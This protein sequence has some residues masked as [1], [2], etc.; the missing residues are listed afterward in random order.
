[1]ASAIDTVPCQLGIG[2][3]TLV[4]WPA[5]SCESAQRASQLIVLSMVVMVDGAKGPKEAL[6]EDATKQQDWIMGNLG[7]AFTGCKHFVDRQALYVLYIY[8]CLLY[9]HYGLSG[10]VGFIVKSLSTNACVLL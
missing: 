2:H 5:P 8:I 7:L 6:L 3:V 1:M 4:G 9:D 10:Y